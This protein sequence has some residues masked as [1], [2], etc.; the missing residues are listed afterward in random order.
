MAKAS[1]APT[2]CMMFGSVS[3]SLNA[4]TAF[5]YFV[6]DSCH[7][8]IFRFPHLDSTVTLGSS[9]LVARGT[10]Q[11]GDHVRRERDLVA[12]C[13][14]GSGARYPFQ[15]P[16]ALSLARFRSRSPPRHV[17]GPLGHSPLSATCDAH[18]ASNPQYGIIAYPR[19]HVIPRHHHR[20]LPR[21]IE[22]TP[23]TLFI[24]KGKVKADIYDK[25]LI[26]VASF[27]LNVG[28]IIVLH[29]GGHGFTMEDDSSMFEVKQ[30]PYA[31]STANDKVQF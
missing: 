14:R 30:G 20:P 6:N 7:L 23:E 28:D 29:A 1:A 15:R 16:L 26:L 24:R 18:S 25:K 3:A 4:S 17:S 27:S 9:P 13:V 22:G 10:G 5:P 19:G 12:L 11:S 31:G 21:T 2:S 8:E